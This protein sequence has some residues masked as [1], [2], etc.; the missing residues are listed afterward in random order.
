MNLI[1]YL[2]I[3]I[4]TE[5]GV[6]DVFGFIESHLNKVYETSG[7]YNLVTPLEKIYNKAIECIEYYGKTQEEYDIPAMYSNISAIHEFAQMRRDGQMTRTGSR[8]FNPYQYLYSKTL[9]MYDDIKHEIESRKGSD[10][11]HELLD[12]NISTK[13]TLVALLNNCVKLIESNP[14]LPDKA[15]AQIVDKI[16]SAINEAKSKT[17]NWSKF[18]GK[19]KQAGIL[20]TAVVAITGYSLKDLIEAKDNLEQTINIVQET[21]INN[22]TITNQLNIQNNIRLI[23]GND[24]HEKIEPEK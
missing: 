10:I 1:E 13:E 5:K 3:D 12:K 2:N 17:T 8:F 14:S 6:N 16:T 4:T 15:K 20:L 19:V 9:E 7:S 23:D 11:F 24:K 21:T 18:L 22:I